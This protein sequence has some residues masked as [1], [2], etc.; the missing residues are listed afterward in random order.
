MIFKNLD[1]RLRGNRGQQRA[2]DFPPGHILRVQ[3][4][5]FGM[6]AFLAQIQFARAVLAG[7]SRSENFMPS[8]I[9]SAMRAGPSSTIVRTT[10]FVAQAR[11][12]F[13]RVAHM[14]LE[15]IFLARHRRDAAL[16]VIRVRFRA[17]LLRD[18]GHAPARR[19]FQRKRQPRNAAAEDE[20]IKLFH[21]GIFTASHLRIVNQP[22]LP[23]EN[24]QRHMRAPLHCVTGSLQRL[25]IKKLNVIHLG[26]RLPLDE[27]HQVPFQRARPGNRFCDFRTVAR[28]ACNRSERHK[29]WRR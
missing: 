8:S 9:N 18:D 21:D 22:C 20:I 14:Q 27:L 26:M 7:I 3:D 28:A 29:A 6:A 17:V 2:F 13:E 19:D 10:A 12:R 11:A 15:R 1:V 25:R 5:P 24:R 16:R 23:Q 4:A